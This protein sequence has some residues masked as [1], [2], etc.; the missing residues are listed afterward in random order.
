MATDNNTKTPAIEDMTFKMDDMTSIVP[1]S[2]PTNFYKQVLNSVYGAN[3]GEKHDEE[4]EEWIWVDGY[5]GTEADMTAWRGFQY[6]LNEM[7]SMDED[8]EIKECHNGFHF[9]PGLKGVFNYFKIGNGHRFFKVRALVRKKDFETVG[10]KNGS[11]SWVF[12]YGRDDKLVAKKIILE[13]ELTPDEIF[14]EEKY[15][16][17]TE[18][19][20]KLAL[21]KSPYEIYENHRFRKLV[22]AGY[23]EIFAKYISKDTDRTERA[24]AVATLPD[25]SMDMKVFTIMYE[26][27]DR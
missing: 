23:S 12:A 21:E 25:V 6:K 26:P 8:A 24:L 27:E 17:W 1:T 5:K 11:P 3:F 13:R 4:E 20:K 16:D 22:E 15:A 2:M 19:E 7:F 10:S 18:D 14:I 9:C